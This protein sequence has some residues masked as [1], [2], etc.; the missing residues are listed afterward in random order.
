MDLIGNV[1]A[2]SLA[3]YLVYGSRLSASNTG[4]SLNMASEYICTLCL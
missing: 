3:A 4:F 2:S 1:F